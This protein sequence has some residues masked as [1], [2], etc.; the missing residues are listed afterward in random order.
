LHFH[1]LFNATDNIKGP[2]VIFASATGFAPGSPQFHIHV[3]VSAVLSPPEQERQAIEESSFKFFPV[4]DSTGKPIRVSGTYGEDGQDP[5]R[6]LELLTRYL[7]E[8]G[9]DGKSILE[10]DFDQGR[11]RL[12]A[13]IVNSYPQVDHVQKILQTIPYWHSKTIAMKSDTESDPGRTWQVDAT[14]STI[15]RGE[16]E[17]LREKGKKLPI[18]PLL[19]FQ[20]GYNVLDDQGKALLGSAYFLVRPFPHPDDASLPVIGANA[21]TIKEMAPNSMVPASF[22]ASAT[23]MMGELRRKAYH[24]W[25]RRMPSSQ[26]EHGLQG[27]KDDL[28][29][30]YLWDQFIIVWQACLRFFRGGRPANIYFVDG[31]FHPLNKP[32]STL[33]GWIYILDEYLAP[34]SSKNAFDRQLVEALYGPAYRALKKLEKELP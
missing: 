23:E 34:T 1:E 3:P 7:A 18:F 14:D 28:Y 11:G 4:P 20:R 31:A 26:K 29:E 19:A 21:Y 30:E 27:M 15:R 5:Y 2:H 6:N 24:E 22:G 9:P 13:L 25:M 33:K 17:R 8:P 12:P 32:R 16:I 10:R